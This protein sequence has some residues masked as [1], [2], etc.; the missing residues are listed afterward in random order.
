MTLFNYCI[1]Y[2]DRRGANAMSLGNHI[3]RR[4]LQLKMSQQELAHALGYKNRSSI[5][6]IEKNESD[7]SQ[8]RLSSLANILNLSIQELVSGDFSLDMKPN[9]GVVEESEL[10]KNSLSGTRKCAA[11]ILAGGSR[12]KNRYNVPYQFVTV[13]NKPII[14]YTLEAFQRHPLIDEIYIVCLEGWEDFLPPYTAEYGIT[15]LKHIIPAGSTGVRSV[16]SAVEY[17]TPTLKASD[18]LVIHEA[19]RPFVEPETISNAIVCCRQYG[20]AITFERLDQLTTFLENENSQ[21]L[22]YVRSDRLI[23]IQSPEL[24]TFGSL[25]QAFY[26]TTKTQHLLDETICAVFMYRLNKNLKFC[27]GTHNNQ[28][29]ISEE[30]LRLLEELK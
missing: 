25:K 17:L 20:S 23:N 28:R 11:V 14:I 1:E 13:N 26:E 29:I 8:A 9:A 4:R 16:K 7:I 22:S 30:D 12:R 5:T 2:K 6:K 24:Y 27:E 3:R 18:I 10:Q 19:T 21:K 15:K